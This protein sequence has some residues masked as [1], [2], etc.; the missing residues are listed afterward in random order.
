MAKKDKIPLN[1]GLFR[2]PLFWLLVITVLGGAFRFYNLNWDLKHS[3]HPDERNI[4]GQTSSIQA[5][6]GYRVQFFAYG[7]LPVYLYRATGELVSTPQFVFDLF[8][9]HDDAAQGVYWVF[10]AALVLGASWFFSREKFQ[11][12]AFGA[13]VFLFACAI[14]LKFFGI[15]TI[16][17]SQID[18]TPLKLANLVLV[19]V[20]A[21]GLSGLISYFLQIEWAGLPLQ[22]SLGAFFLMGVLPWFLANAWA[23]VFGELAFTLLLCGLAS[24]WAWV[25]RWGRLVLT[26]LA[27]WTWLAS[28]AHA[29]HV[30]TGYGEC[31][32]IGRWWAALFST[33]TI[34]AIYH[35][36][37]RAYQNTPM[38]LLAA[39]GFAF[40]VVSI[41]QAHYCITES[42]IT[43]M[44]VVIAFCAHEIVRKG[45]WREYLLAGAAFGL[46]MAAKTSSLYYVMIIVTAHLVRLA[47]RP[48]KD[49]EK[50]WK[51][52][53]DYKEIYS[54][55][56]AG[57]MAATL[58]VFAG[59]GFKLRGVLQDLFT[60]D[61][62]FANNLWVALFA[63][64]SLLGLVF[65][66]WEFT[67]FRVLAAQAP[68]WIKIA[69]TGGLAVFLF[70]LFS[71]WSLLDYTGF[72]NS[73]NYEWHVVS[74]SDACYVIQFKDTPR[75]LYQLWNLM[76][77]EL[78]WPLG[79]AAVA[80]MLWVLGRFLLQLA[81]PTKGKTLLPL[82]LV[83]G[84]GFTFSLPDL[85]IL[86]WFIP[87]FGFIGSWNTKFVRY[88][89]PLVPAFCVFAARLLADLYQRFKSFPWM[90][91]AK[92][93]V[94]TVVLGASLFYSAAYMHVYRFPHPWIES[95]VW[96]F[97][98][99]PLGAKIMTETWDDGLPTGVDHSQDPRVEGAM[100]PQNFG[101]VDL[102]IYEMHGFPTDDTPVKKN[103]Y[104]NVL[105]QGDYI[106]I[107]SKKMWYTLTACT[108]EF[109]PH[110]YN[111]YPVTSRYYRLL[112]SGLLGFKMVGE[113]HNYPGLFGWEHP[114]DMAEESFSVYDHPRVYIFKKV[115]NVPPER[116][117][118]MLDSDDY[119]KG[120]DRDLMR[121][122][123]P[124]N[125]DQFIADRR[126]YL[127]EKGLLKA[128][129][130]ISPA[131]TPQVAPSPKA[132]PKASAKETTKASAP[133]NAQGTPSP[134][135]MIKVTAPPTVPG[136]P[137]AKTLQVLKGYADHPFVE[138]DVSQ[139][140]PPPEEGFFYQ[141]RAWFSWLLILVVLG[142]MALPL[143]LKVLP[144]L[145]S[146][147]YSLSKILGFFAYCW[148]VWFSASVK[149]CHFTVGSCWFWFF[150]LLG[151][152]L[153]GFR[154]D[155]G[156][157]K[158]AYAK[159]GESWKHQ[160][161]AFVAAFAAFTLVKIY[162]PHIHDPSGEGY[163]G[164]GEAG[165]DFGFL[166]SVVRGENF[167]PQN[168]WMAG[169][170]IGY[171][172][173]Y[174]HLMMGILTK[175]LG[176]VPA[177]TYNLALITLFAMIFSGCFGLAFGLTGNLPSGWI[178]G[179]LS[180]VAGNPAGAK[181]YLEILHQCFTTGNFAALAYH[182]YDF[183]GPTRVIPP[184]S[185]NEFPYFSVL[186]GD[187]HAH[188]LAQPFAMLLI[189]IVASLYIAQP[190][191]PFEWGRDLPSL[192]AAGFLLGGIAYLNTWEVP[193]WVLLIGIALLTRG[194]SG[195][196]GK[197]LQKGL[198]RT[199][200]AV[201]VALLLLGWKDFLK[202]GSMAHALGG[203]TLTLAVFGF[204]GAGAAV[205]WLNKDKA[206]QILSRQFLTV[207]G[208]FGVVFAATGVLWI[209]FFKIF[210]PQQSTIMWVAPWIRTSVR[211]Y[212]NIYGFFV[213]VLAL[214][215]LAAFRA[216]IFRWLAAAVKAPRK[217]KGDFLDR[218]N[219]KLEELSDKVIEC[220]E[221]LLA[222]KNAVQGAIAL[223]L[224]SLVVIWGASWVEWTEPPNYS[225]FSLLLATLS[226]GLMLAALHFK[227]R[228]EW[229]LATSGVALLWMG[230]MATHRI[231]LIQEMPFTL[232]LFFF[233]VL[234]LVGFF[235]LGLAV[236]TFADRKL[237]FS[238]LLT[239][240]LFLLTA[241]LEVF[242][243]S[244]YFG[245]GDGMRNNSLFKYGINAW[246]V[247]SVAAGIFLPKILAFFKEASKAVK[248]ESARSR[249]T[250]L[251]ISGLFIYAL[252]WAV[253][254]VYFPY[255]QNVF[256]YLLDIVLTAGLVGWG[257]F[258]DE[259]F[260]G[261]GARKLFMG[262]AAVLILIPILAWMPA[263]SSA[264]LGFIQHHCAQFAAEWQFPA[265]LA[266]LA[267]FAANLVW[268]GKKNLGLYLAQLSWK[269]L[270][271][272]LL[273]LICVYP[274]AA[275][276]RKA[277]GFL[278]V[279]RRQWGGAVESPTLDGLAYLRRS[280]PYDAAAI[281][282]LN[283]HIPD[284][285]CL[286]EFVGAG[287]NTWGSR[288][289][290]FTG[291]PAL[292]GWNGHVNE[293]VGQ[294]LGND[295]QS[296]YNATEETFSTTDPVLAK[297]NLDAYGV[298]LVMVG[299]VER[300]GAAEKRG[301]PAEGLDKFSSF[302]PLIY[303]N[304]GVEI[305]Y[306]PPPVD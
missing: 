158:S 208:S 12:P 123:T 171:T 8:K 230:L 305:Y 63:G 53:K 239:A 42:F 82:P 40:A 274:A 284:Q 285:P 227:D 301:Y 43:L 300:N 270:V 189:G 41:E 302:L 287:Y 112:W 118:K 140:P 50:D 173:Y 298:R 45:G 84:K 143:T 219:H 211:N 252:L 113:F 241:T 24:W 149:I 224:G 281:R 210:Y 126:K 156:G 65:F 256:I 44:F 259:W 250:L 33:A 29:G 26:L 88:M 181:Q 130:E 160:E 148:V 70:C 16:W 214:A 159:W 98:H 90:A 75:Y 275:S 243:M 69:S 142:W 203:S 153:W 145:P 247:A 292:M 199:F 97:K 27:F 13:S 249:T 96:M 254:D 10:L 104:A 151:L 179:L 162:I 136:L 260:T 99:I 246:T 152:A 205:L 197:V 17:F 18:D 124:D 194:L 35:F 129:E 209:P 19:A 297:K 216:E 46:A 116:I 137:D 32:I 114:D 206:T 36:V 23:R 188:T 193:T 83:E 248:K 147:A 295:I 276:T 238:Y 212:F 277:H 196:N 235:H 103:Y 71:P 268:E 134:T 257:L 304:P 60:L 64:L 168:M 175:T 73:M 34:A 154:K 79:V 80:G 195:A 141:L 255:M 220:S 132:K 242:V 286:M 127:E 58:G 125:V 223:G 233:S 187:M 184:L 89:V 218:V 119:V 91:I 226:V 222:P 190:V 174:G 207:A 293:W 269:S 133:A 48:A 120:I 170:P 161:W 110:G 20:V 231:H 109:K 244:E 289:S 31:M 296:R 290:I 251:V 52:L 115:E 232:D 202:P 201:L 180:A 102:T 217:P 107:A 93:V 94:L 225:V 38:A 56:A 283:E 117:L 11:I 183:F 240:F 6:S 22:A 49:W 166:A 182:T 77:V 245:F 178:A 258:V 7:Q 131:A 87:Y 85:L 191:K 39:A 47:Q 267:V 21:L 100:G 263:S 303:K 74:I 299:T 144:N 177:V 164:G 264:F 62:G 14:F 229:W 135:P 271:V 95:S 198:T 253:L 15:F 272:A 86:C 150:A 1:A 122:I 163:N 55:V 67:R 5:G 265:L 59:V 37:N 215:F 66:I 282:F 81:R 9:G 157:V 101:H 72:M 306:N 111:V 200:Q 236:K 78:W 237:S 288:F 30:Y 138:T 25:S 192:A 280:N 3:F 169:L 4:L 204:L 128:L 273:T 2:K 221:T 51:K 146:G 262:M 54:L 167:P 261:D 165:M 172:F 279:F 186:Y 108:P 291:I 234:W 28:M 278:D 213:S 228:W 76:H 61:P 139:A 68:E 294:R 266:S 185:I 106:S 155:F 105:Q 121:T 176:L 57:L 92:P